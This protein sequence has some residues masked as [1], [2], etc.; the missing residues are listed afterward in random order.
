MNQMLKC[1]QQHYHIITDYSYCISVDMCE[2]IVSVCRHVSVDMCESI[3]SVCRH[4]S[5]MYISGH[6]KFD[7]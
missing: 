1:H 4:V 3:V 5:V 2:S 6:S 7:N